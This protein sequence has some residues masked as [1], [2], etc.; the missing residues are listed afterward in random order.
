MCSSDLSDLVGYIDSDW[1][2]S[3]DDRKSTSGYV[4]HMGSGAISCASKKQPIV[5]LSA[6]E[7]EYV[8]ATAATC[9]AIWMRRMLRSLCQEQVKGIVIYCDNSSAIASSKN[10]VFHKRTKHID[11]KFHY[12]R[13]LVNNGEIILQHCK[14]EEKYA[15][16][17][18]K[19]LGQKTFEFLRK[20]FGM[21]GNLAVEFKGEC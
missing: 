21:T 3:V 1:V 16:I 9:Q 19:P 12:I 11:T 2:G 14:T 18:T 5:A 15:D 6:A 4:F 7:A 10:S 13:E 17:L 8:A 20:C